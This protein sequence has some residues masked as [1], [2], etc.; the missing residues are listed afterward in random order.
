MALVDESR[1]SA[2]LVAN[3]VEQRGDSLIYGRLG[4]DTGPELTLRLS[5]IHA[6]GSGER[7]PLI[8][9]S[10]H[11]HLFDPESGRRVQ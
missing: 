1:A 9:R 7:L 5:G 6:P 4:D 10:A 11:I 2:H 8:A 3:P